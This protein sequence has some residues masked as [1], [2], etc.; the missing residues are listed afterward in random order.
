MK[1]TV[2]SHI[3][4]EAYYLQ[5]WLTYHRQVFDHGIIID[6]DSTDGSMDIVRELCPTWE[7]ITS[8][9]RDFG[10]VECDREVM[11]IE[12]RVTGYK[13][14]LNTTEWLI[15]RDTL[16][17]LLPDSVSSYVLE[18]EPWVLARGDVSEVQDTVDFISKFDRV[19]KGYDQ[20]GGFRYLHNQPNGGYTAGRHSTELSIP[21][22]RSSDIYLIWAGLFPNNNVVLQR[23]LGI[24]P[25]IPIRDVQRSFGSQHMRDQ[26]AIKTEMNGVTAIGD[27]LI[28]DANYMT[29][30]KGAVALVYSLNTSV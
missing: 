20:R 24:M 7:I 2:I 15:C 16:S 21:R 6:Y 13:M 29:A 5:F 28:A 14:A 19:V 1:A 23:K 30:L 11:D 17:N 27:D 8:R 9:N 3:Y 10:A 25:R 26:D 12:T 22:S 4:N 18:L